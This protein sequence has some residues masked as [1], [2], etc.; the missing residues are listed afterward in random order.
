LTLE[1]L[2]QWLGALFP[3][4]F[5]GLQRI[6]F[7]ARMATFTVNERQQKTMKELLDAGPQGL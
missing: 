3:S 7:Q 2:C 6:S 1:R 4:G 5:S